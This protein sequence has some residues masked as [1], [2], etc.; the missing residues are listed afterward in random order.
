MTVDILIKARELHDDL[1]SLRDAVEHTSCGPA[2]KSALTR[3]LM[4]SQERVD[5]VIRACGVSL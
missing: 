2:V 5:A 4:E 1:E 3:D